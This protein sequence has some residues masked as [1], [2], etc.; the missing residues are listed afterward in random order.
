MIEEAL[1][2]E[3][4]QRL[5]ALRA[6]RDALRIA[7]RK[8]RQG[9]GL[10]PS[11]WPRE[12][13]SAALPPVHCPICH[14]RKEA[15]EDFLPCVECRYQVREAESKPVKK[16]VTD[17]LGAAKAKQ[18]EAPCAARP[19][20]TAG[21]TFLERLNTAMA[22]IAAS[23]RGYGAERLVGEK[24]LNY[25]GMLLLV[26]GGAF[27]LK[28]T[29][30]FSGA[31]GKLAIGLAAGAGLIF[32]GERLRRQAEFELFSVPV[33]GGGWILAY[34]TMFAAHY[35][36]ASRVIESAPAGFFLVCLTAAGMIYHSLKIR[37]RLLTVFAFGTAYF[38]FAVTHLGVQ[39]L[40]VCAVLALSGAW[41]VRELKHPELAAVNLAG[42]Y[43]NYF[44]VLRSVLA[45]TPAE[46]FPTPDFW[47]S[48]GAATLVHV[49]Y[50][51]AVP[52]VKEG[53]E[54]A[55][56]MDAFLSL[57]AILYAGFAYSQITSFGPASSA[58]ALLGVAGVLTGLSA[59]R[60]GKA[61]SALGSV[62]AFLAAFVTAQAVFKLGTPAAQLWGFGLALGVFGTLAVWLQRRSFE[63]YAFAMAVLSG[64]VALGN[65]PLLHTE[66]RLLA[67]AALLHTGLVSY[68]LA[69]LRHKHA[70]PDKSW[71]GAWFAAGLAFTLASQ[72]L[73][74]QPAA[75]VLAVIALALTLEWA[76][77]LFSAPD[78][79]Q[80]AVLLE[81]GAG[82]GSFLI[83]YGANTPIIGSITSRTLVSFS[84]SGAY[85]YLVFGGASP[86]GSCLGV[87]YRGWR[88]AAAWLMSAVAAFG[89]YHG[90]DPRLRL[91]LWS[92]ASLLLLWLARGESEHRMDLRAQSYLLMLGTAAEG[93][94]SYLYYPSALMSVLDW[95]STA[96]YGATALSLLLPMTWKSW[97][98]GEEER[99][100]E[101]GASYMAS[102]LSLTL[103]ALFI[104]K[105]CNG[106]YITLGW[107]LAGVTY[108]IAGLLANKQTLRLP[109]L[110][111][112]CLCVGKALFL[113][114]SG[115]EL[116]LRVL[117]FT[118]L[119]ALLV[120]SSYLYVQRTKEVDADAA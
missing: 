34:Y 91:P 73:W 50:A 115:L 105:E 45:A 64:C 84:L 66:H 108:L 55:P 60:G 53:D 31:Y 13:A 114:M 42:F 61:R 11:G 37:S 79:R 19:T 43:L 117:S 74:L 106:A 62:Q 1:Q 80:Q 119:G 4:R 5:E 49:V 57:S 47:W 25:V 67:G 24:L 7:R 2:R 77:E 90:F 15:G 32:A 96:V 8:R 87:S 12:A 120:L 68:G 69:L 9:A 6:Q 33:I 38:A 110:V 56:E 71:T 72:W 16:Q 101:Q 46:R 82:A 86:E 100:E 52:A 75:F 18:A 93:V 111:L 22:A 81:V 30:D 70:C 94:L 95:R 21:P 3:R 35:L 28:Y 26:L 99:R 107:T 78:L 113:D 54:P 89:I 23:V 97:A 27:F 10:E 98:R 39:S 92:L 40:T 14:R 112:V 76:A 63:K 51:L 116:P 44:P 83:D 17:P 85:G 102:L 41:L 103:L 58:A 29:F 59:A 20:P 118:V 65:W 104:A 109:G 88:Q 36:P 48:L